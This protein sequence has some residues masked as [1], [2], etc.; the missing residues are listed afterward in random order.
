[1]RGGGMCCGGRR[2]SLSAPSAA[3]G[4]HSWG[5]RPHRGRRGRA[6]D[7]ETN[8]LDAEEKAIA[9]RR[10]ETEGKKK[11]PRWGLALSGGGIRSSTF[12]LGL[13]KSLARNKLLTRLDYLSTVSGGG[14]AGSALGRLFQSVK[15]PAQVQQGLEKDGTVL[16]WWLRKNGRYLFPAGVK[17]SLFATSTLLR[18]LTA[19]YFDLF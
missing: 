14:Y 16:W 7:G 2:G 15:D 10:G 5:A 9:A 1:M 6:M 18:G 4:L 13:M 12:C 8:W 19:I 3:V 11:S 17:D